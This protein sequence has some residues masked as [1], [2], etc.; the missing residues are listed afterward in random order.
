MDGALDPAQMEP[1]ARQEFRK[2]R[3]NIKQMNKCAAR[4]LLAISRARR[5]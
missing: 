1:M 4:A 5:P 3:A 2:M